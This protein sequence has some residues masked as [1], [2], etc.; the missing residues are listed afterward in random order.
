MTF[1]YS[2][3]SAANYWQI[4]FLYFDIAV[5]SLAFFRYWKDHLDKRLL[6]TKIVK[7][8]NK[9]TLTYIQRIIFPLLYQ[10]FIC[11][12][13]GRYYFATVLKYYSKKH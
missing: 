5:L 3:S 1:K 7:H 2:S 8:F 11:L 4:S 9:R 6:L 13:F 12:I 10:I